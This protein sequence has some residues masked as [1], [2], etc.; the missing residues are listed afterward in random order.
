M[1]TGPHEVRLPVFGLPRTAHPPDLHHGLR[2]SGRPRFSQD[3]YA[4]DRDRCRRPEKGRA[5]LG[6]PGDH[7][8]RGRAPD[9]ACG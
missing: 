4:P 6:K 7:P 8:D 9:P 3:L 2:P 1:R 5:G